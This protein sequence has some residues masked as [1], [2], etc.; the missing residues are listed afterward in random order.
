VADVVG[1]M[2][3]PC[4]LD[5]AEI[6]A[7]FDSMA[8]RTRAGRRAA[9]AIVLLLAT[10]AR[11]ADRWVKNGGDDDLDGSSPATAWATLGHAADEVGPG[12]T[13]HVLDGTYQGFYLTTSGTPGNPITFKAEGPAVEITADNPIT[14]DGINLE[15]ASHVVIDGFVVNGRTR[16]GV[17]AVLASFVTVRNCKLGFNGRWG[18]LTGFVDDFVAENNEAHHSEIEHGIYVSNS[19]DRPIVRNNW[20]HDN[21]ANGLHFNGDESQGGDGLIENALVEGN[22][23]HGNGVGGGSGINMDG[24]VNGV[25][26]NNLLYDNHAS[27]ISLYRI[28]ASAGATGNLVVNNTI[29][30]AADGRWCVNISDGSTGNTVR[31]NILYSFHSFRGAISIDAASRPGFVSDYNSVMDQMSIDGGDSAIGFAAWQALGYDAHSFVA[32]PAQHFLVPGA[33]FHLLDSSPALDAGS[34]AGAPAFDLDGNPRPVGA[35]VDLGAYERQLLECDDGGADPGEQCGEPGLACADPCTA[36]AQCICA[37]TPATC[38]DGLV[39]GGEACEQDADCGGGLVCQGCQC[40]NPGVCASGIAL[41]KP[42]QTL[43]ASPARIKIRAD[44]TIPQP[45]LG[46][47]PPSNGIRVV[48]DSPTGPGGIDLTIPG[49]GAWTARDARWTYRDP[50]GSTGGITKVVVQD[51]S[52]RTPGWLR[53]VVKGKDGS[54]VLPDPAATRTTLVVGTP[55]EC[56]SIAWN[57]PNGAAPRC[58]GDAARLTCK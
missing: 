21:H 5:P 8:G 26:R 55:G 12:D 53:V 13:V 47:D 14:P 39:C 6:S 42:R 1:R 52:R 45:W 20:V 36:C 2:Q 15:G 50:L 54:I 17:R 51:R 19:C 24:G 28:D 33:D 34:A 25:V 40:T 43:R 10:S 23:I 58:R 32:T 4:A 29:L 56:A 31:N 44:V 37:A 48:V 18:I 35:A 49:G 27:G 22:V 57:G 46:I 16:T 11:A 7:R 41:V 3:T 30:S 9:V 38:G